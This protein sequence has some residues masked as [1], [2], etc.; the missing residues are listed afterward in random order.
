M[1]QAGERDRPGGASPE[2]PS[3]QWGFWVVFCGAWLAVFGLWTSAAASLEDMAVLDAA[4]MSAAFVVP[5]AGFAAL[6]GLAR[7]RLIR[8]DWS[9][10]RTAATLAA[11]GVVYAVVAGWLAS[12]A[13]RAVYRGVSDG[14]EAEMAVQWQ[15]VNV[16]FLYAIFS[17]FMMWSESV[18]RVHETRTALAREGML[19]AQAEAKAIRAQFNPHFVF[20][21]LHSLMLLVRADPATAERAIEDVGQLIRY[22]STLQRREVD[23]VPL[24]EELGVVRR[25]LGLERLR[26]DHRLHVVWDLD[27]ELDDQAVPAFGIQ[28]LVENS[29]KHGVEPSERGGTVTIRVRREADGRV[30]VTVADDGAGVGDRPS[31][32][33]RPTPDSLAGHG[34]D[35]LA[36]R[37]DALHGDAASLSWGPAAGGGFTATFRVPTAPARGAGT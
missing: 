33:S 16:L 19:R 35:L 12:A 14:V 2:A 37:L 6:I 15:V 36:R 28:T 17:G 11:V 3:T 26:L 23:E 27:E 31:A 25:Y 29:I 20:N 9:L 8:P 30:A 10:L 18:R 4:A 1:T 7:H 13:M 21:T 5:V 24:T 22:A 34:L 32:G